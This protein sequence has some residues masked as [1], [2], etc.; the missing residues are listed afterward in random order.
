LAD[1]ERGTQILLAD[2]GVLVADVLGITG[3]HLIAESYTPDNNFFW[4]QVKLPLEVVRG[5]IFRPP[6]VPLRRDLL[7]AQVVTARGDQDQLLLD[8][9]DV[10]SGTLDTSSG[11]MAEDKAR[12][13]FY[14]LQEVRLKTK[15]GVIPIS[16][17]KIVAL[18]FNPALVHTAKPQSRPTRMG[19]R[20]GS[21]FD[22]IR[23]GA[24]GGRVQLTLAIGAQLETNAANLWAETSMLQPLS[25]GVVY[26]PDIKPV[27][28]K[29]IPFLELN[30]PYRD[31]HN[32]LGGRLRTGG[33]IYGKGL[34]MHSTSRLAYQ[35]D[36]RYRKFEAELA[37]DDSAG[38]RG[39]VE[40]RVF[41]ESGAGQWQPA[42]SSPVIRGADQPLPISIDISSATRI[43]LIVDF[44]D[45]GDELDHA[46]WLNARLIK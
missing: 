21:C 25:D 10:L 13:T 32:V 17:E 24:S 31:D 9:G 33:L 27:G 11:E 2:G 12:L 4:G 41:L 36:R 6:A 35:T 26:L 39:S 1:R 3:E 37:L 8:N 46:N 19:F 44:S 45:R 15:A 22:V 43:A 30:W 29:H 20:D 7:A 38:R 28:Y 42:Y 14:G 23:V 5:I 40:F 34:G 18:I 16:I